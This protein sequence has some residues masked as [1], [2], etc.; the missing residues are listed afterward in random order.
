MMAQIQVIGGLAVT[1]LMVTNIKESCDREFDLVTAKF[2]NG[3]VYVSRK[4]K[5]LDRR[6][7]LVLESA[8]AKRD[9]A[10]LGVLCGDQFIR[11]RA[12]KNHGL[13]MGDAI[14]LTEGK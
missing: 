6:S 11:M 8:T 3:S 4:V 10:E 1:S 5:P 14:T 7:L 12:R 13:E 9:M 2:L